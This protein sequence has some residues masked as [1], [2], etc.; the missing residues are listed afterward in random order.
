MRL[1]SVKQ[2]VK[3]ST[4]SVLIEEIRMFF[5]LFCE[6]SDEECILIQALQGESEARNFCSY[7]RYWYEKSGR[8]GYKTALDQALA[9]KAKIAERLFTAP[10]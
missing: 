9:S 4:V 5:M 10:T 2:A 3:D 6:A 1:P 7:A 8:L